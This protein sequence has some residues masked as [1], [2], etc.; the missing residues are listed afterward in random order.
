MVSSK[1]PRNKEE[2]W[3]FKRDVWEADDA[4]NE[5][6]GNVI[7]CLKQTPKSSTAEFRTV[8]RTVIPA[9]HAAPI[10]AI[11]SISLV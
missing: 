4:G 1:F 3:N 9:S 10:V 5:A 7:N 6:A 8:Q 11:N 2:K